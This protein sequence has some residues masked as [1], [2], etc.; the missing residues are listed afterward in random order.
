MSYIKYLANIFGLLLDNIFKIAQYC[1]P[2]KMN[3]IWK[4]DKYSN[5]IS[6]SIVWMVFT[7]S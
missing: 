6:T 7:V 4:A 3:S 1:H 5:L 2:F